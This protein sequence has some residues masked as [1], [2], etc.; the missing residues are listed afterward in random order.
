[1]V[2]F[3]LFYRCVYNICTYLYESIWFIFLSICQKDCVIVG[4][5]NSR[6]SRNLLTVLT[7]IWW[8]KRSYSNPKCCKCNG[9]LEMLHQVVI[10]LNKAL[11]QL[12][13]NITM[14]QSKISKGNLLRCVAP[15]TVF[16]R[17]CFFI[18]PFVLLHADIKTIIAS[19]Q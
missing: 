14:Y 4:G 5:F 8:A 17:C 10:N 12:F 11:K 9:L 19:K 1:M 18:L 16:E 13:L 2:L 15:A 3:Y 6:S 7:N